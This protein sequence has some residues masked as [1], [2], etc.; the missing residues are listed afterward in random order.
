MPS[1]LDRLLFRVFLSCYPQEFRRVHCREIEELY[2]W[3]MAVSRQRRGWLPARARGLFD[4]MRGAVALRRRGDDDTSRW[5]M[6]SFGQDVRFALRACRRAP[7]F[8]AGAL[9]VLALGIGANGAIFSL[10]R[11]VLFEPLPYARPDE[12]VMVW[13]SRP[14]RPQP[15]VAISTVIKNW[16]DR[17]GG[18]LHDIAA[19]RMWTGNLEAQFDLVHPDGA[20]RLRAGLV[21]PNFFSVL[22]TAPMLGRVFT[23]EDEI[24]GHTNLVVLGHALWQR[25]FA[26]DDAVIGRT[27]TFVAGRRDRSPKPF[28]I[29]GVMPPA[30]RFTYPVDTEL[31]TILPWAE[32]NADSGAAIQYNQAVARLAPGLDFETANRRM[33]D[34]DPGYDRPETDPRQRS[35]THLQRMSAWVSGE[36][37]PM[38]ILLGGVAVLLLVIACATVANGSLVRLAERQRELALRAALGAS[39]ARLVRQLLTEGL[40][41][42]LG[43]TAL[44]CAFAAM[45]LPAFRRLVPAVV[46]RADEMTISV[47]MIVFAAAAATVV[48]LLAALVPA[49]HGARQELAVSMRA[50]SS[51]ASASR[52]SV[53][54]RATL[55]GLQAGVATALLV[56]AALLL[57]SF[58]RL[59]RVDVGFNADGVWTVEMRMMDRRYFQPAAMATF[60]RALVDRVRGVPGVTDVGLTTAVPFRGVDFLRTYDPPG[61]ERRPGDPTPPGCPERSISGHTRSVDPAFF[62]IMQIPLQRG[63]L[64]QPSDTASSAKVVVLSESFA[65]AMFGDRNPVGERLSSGAVEIVG[66]VGDARYVSFQAEARGAVYYPRSQDPAELLCLIVKAAPG[67]GPMEPALR[68]AVRDV[69]PS[70]PAMNITTIDRILAESIADRRFYTATTMAFAALALL[71]TASGLIVVIARSVIERRKEMAI[72]TALG[73]NAV[74]L[75]AL[76]AR[77]GVIPV[78]AGTITGMIGAGFGARL[79]EPFLFQM[80][81]HD[82]RVYAAA[83]ILTVVVG[84]L[85]SLLPANRLTRLSPTAVLKE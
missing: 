50:T 15:R 25:A 42:S 65:R 70:V 12:V 45:L 35:R 83:G 80:S 69:D 49:M 31:W 85:A 67:A 19:T 63:R 28:T 66:V 26:G 58:W 64:I 11:A 75:V 38:V 17:N 39:R 23:N 76:A 79:L 56:G 62:S 24:A 73:A 21:T 71:L 10:A 47:W 82:L 13:H 34:V 37:R 22:G 55:V 57:I 7:L 72:R 16:R 48:T 60:Q 33:S 61:C 40:L 27:V 81:I 9:F 6:G 29:V 46:P 53:R 74:Q 4:A 2:A 51:T 3:S 18:V 78:A 68:R 8:T 32:I 36:T 54:W 1:G 20:E 5:S 84:A 77:Q 14:D 59:G 52:S 30:F 41:L 43:G 44:G